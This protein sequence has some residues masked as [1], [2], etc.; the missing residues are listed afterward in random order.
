MSVQARLN[1]DDPRLYS[2]SRDVAH[3]FPAVVQ[4]VWARL[5]DGPNRWPELNALLKQ[6]TVGLPELRAAA[7]AFVVFVCSATADPRETMYAAL[8]RAGWFKVN[9]VAQV[10]YMAYVGQVMAGIFFHGA[11]EATI[12]GIGPLSDVRSLVAAGRQ[13][14]LD[15]WWVATLPGA[16]IFLVSLGFNLAGDGLVQ[17]L[18]PRSSS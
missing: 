3:N 4:E 10:A 16:A 13:V 2:A 11:R 14:L 5:L 15:Q 1:R 17:L 18:D 6:H 8:Q 9:P 7:E 12:G